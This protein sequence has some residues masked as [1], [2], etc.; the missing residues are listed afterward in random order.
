[1][2]RQ[3]VWCQAVWCP[4]AAPEVM[5]KDEPM[6]V[7]QLAAI[8]AAAIAAASIWRNVRV[9]RRL[10][11]IDVRLAT[12]Q[13]E[14]EVLQMQESRRVMMALKRN[15][16]VASPDLDPGENGPADGDGDDRVRLVGK[17]RATPVP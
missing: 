4:R 1:M 15:A 3:A 11:A 10:R 5:H 2:L 17:P 12:M 8:A 16:N 6:I 14:I 13:K 9:H 7:Y